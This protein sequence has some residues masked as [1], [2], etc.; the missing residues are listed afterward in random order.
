MFASII[1]FRALYFATLLLQIGLGLLNT[2]IAL[3]LSSNN[4]DEFWIGALMA[5]YYVGLVS[6]GKLGY[7]LIAYAGHIRTYVAC[8]GIST[9]AVL[10]HS[11]SDLLTV[12]LFLRC[13]I[14]LAIMCQYMVLESWLNEQSSSETRGTVFSGYMLS[15]HLGIIL[16]QIVLLVH[17]SLSIELLML[18]AMCF[19]L[20]LVPVA[21]T[22]RVHPTPLTITP[23]EPKYFLKAVPKSLTTVLLSG[24]VTGSFYGLAPLYASAHGLA[25]DKVGLFMACCILAGLLVQWPL[26]LLSDRV[27]RARLIRSCSLLLML[28]AVPLALIAE[29]NY[30]L[31]FISGFAV[32]SFQF[33]LYPLGVAFAN[34]HVKPER[35]VSLSAMLLMAVGIGSCVGALVAGALM[36]YFGANMLYIFVMVCAIAL[37]WRIRPDVVAKLR[38]ADDAPVPHVAMPDNIGSQLTVALD[39]RV[40]E[41]IVQEQMMLDSAHNTENITSADNLAPNK[42]DNSNKEDDDDVSNL[43]PDITLTNNANIGK[44]SKDDKN[45]IINDKEYEITNKNI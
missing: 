19:A 27:D 40:D 15:T 17:P 5:A 12:W 25:T 41:Q 33:C 26:G 28:S 39:P 6:G 24:M 11:F 44:N 31:L 38:V 35:R 7:R 42:E 16:G 30:Q 14:G 20:C 34:D 36:R 29:D 22:H 8:A 3:R 9:A 23:M 4:V 45:S 1:A 21:L 2:Y 13:I 18:I 37:V 32:C 43:E 10:A